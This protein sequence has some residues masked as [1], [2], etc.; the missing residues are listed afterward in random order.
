MALHDLSVYTN[1]I[2]HWLQ[3]CDEK[4]GS[5]CV[6]PEISA[7]SPDDVP[8]WLI[9][10]AQRCIVR[11]TDARRYVA[12]SY[13]WPGRSN[14]QGQLLLNRDKLGPFQLPGFLHNHEA[15]PEVIKDAMQLVEHIGERYLWVDRFCIL[16]DDPRIQVKVQ[17]MDRIYSGAYLTI[18][19]AAAPG[20]F[21]DKRRKDPNRGPHNELSLIDMPN[22]IKE[23]EVMMKDHYDGLSWSYWS[24]RG[25]TYQEQILCRRA[26]FFLRTEIFWDCQLKI[27]D[28]GTLSPSQD[29]ITISP[30]WATG[31]RL[32]LL[33]EPDF[34][35]YCDLVCPYNE[36]NFSY[37]QDALLAFSGI[38]NTLCQ[39]FPGGFVYG[40]PRLF[41]DH[42][43]LWQPFTK[44]AR[45]IDRKDGSHDSSP[46]SSLPSWSWCGWKCPVDPYSM[47]S[48]F[49]YL[50][51]DHCRERAASWQTRNLIQWNTTNGNAGDALSIVEPVQL[52]RQL[53]SLS[54]GSA[55]SSLRLELDNISSLTGA[56]SRA[57][58]H[59]GALFVA[60]DKIKG[61]MH[62]RVKMSVFENGKFSY[63]PN[64]TE[65]PS[66]LILQ[67]ERCNPAGHLRLMNDEPIDFNNSLE[68]IAISTGSA[69]H[70]DFY[71]CFEELVYR[72]NK[73]ISANRK[74]EMFF[75]VAKTQGDFALPERWKRMM[76][77]EDAEKRCHFY[78]VLWIER[79]DR[80]AFRRA[81]GRVPRDIWE[82]NASGP[83]HV[84][85]G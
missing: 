78:N 80:I 76:F 35:I 83:T 18:I 19:A 55:V 69:N 40:I 3:T 27:W 28:E 49:A 39:T 60:F 57:F 47:R 61:Y 34:S 82:A 20:L 1:P 15:L 31:K 67:D 64:Y 21:S 46:S 66:V 23:E 52:E 8:D 5:T 7:R 22:R 9:D 70:S 30:P 42:V 75:K 24:T 79:K 65:M 56:T 77:A 17:R 84:V 32:A 53:P 59:P 74:T 29:E 63:G 4:H 2:R 51:R 81:C 12:L 45:R 72:E 85:L 10:T 13:V 71:S 43:L 11:G 44:A 41:L 54:P 48:G 58:F 73:V 25:W 14:T 26:V 50:D 33:R 62:A 68:L 16:Q 38:L 6:P 36:R 37:P